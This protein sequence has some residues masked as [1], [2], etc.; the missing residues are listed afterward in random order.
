MEVWRVGYGGLTVGKMVGMYS[1]E[2]KEWFLFIY[3]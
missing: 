1:R 2:V 3:S